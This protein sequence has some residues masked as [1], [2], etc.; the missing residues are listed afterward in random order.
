MSAS[1]RNIQ[2]TLGPRQLGAGLAGLAFAAILIVALAASQLATSI[3]SIEGSK[4]FTVTTDPMAQANSIG[5]SGVGVAT[6]LTVATDPMAQ[7]NSIGKSGVGVATTF[8]PGT[9]PMADANSIGKSGVGV[10]DSSTTSN[11]AGSRGRHIPQ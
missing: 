8:T 11:G 1:T 6:T 9:D 7:A 5:M 10:P 3:G 4:G 2:G